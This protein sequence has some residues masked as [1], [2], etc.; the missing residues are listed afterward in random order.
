MKLDQPLPCG[1]TRPP[2]DGKTPGWECTGTRLLVVAM[3]RMDGEDIPVVAPA[4]RI[5]EIIAMPG[6]STPTHFNG[7]DH[8]HLSMEPRP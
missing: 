7:G 3:T 5:E 4:S 2:V 1:A 6:L 8:L